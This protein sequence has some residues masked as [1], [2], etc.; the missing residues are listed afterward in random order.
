MSSIYDEVILEHIRNARNYRELPDATRR[1]EG[2]NPLCGDTFTVYLALEGERIRDAAFQ[3]SCCGIS[4]A[5]ASV[6]TGLVRDRSLDEAARMAHQFTQLVRHPADSEG[7][8][9]AAD[10]QAILSVVRASPSRGN[11]AALAWHTLHAAL[12][13]EQSTTLQPDG[14]PLAE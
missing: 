10:Q 7:A 8:E 1:A 4:M 2:I 5:S 6:M 9:V 3:C 13:G 14:Q 12:R 11:C